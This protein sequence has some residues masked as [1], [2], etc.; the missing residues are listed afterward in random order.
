MADEKKTFKVKVKRTNPGEQGARFDT[1]EVPFEEKM[2][3]FN[4]LEYIGNYLDPSLAFYASC[5]IGKC[6]GC[7][8]MANGKRKLACT[9]LVEGDLLLEPDTR[10]KV[11]RDLVV[12]MGE[13]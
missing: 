3:I 13:L 7:T 12:D 1:F 8:L 11:I 6:M 9:T 2:S 10:F 4:A 5:R